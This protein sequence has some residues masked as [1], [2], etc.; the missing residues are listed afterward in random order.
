MH[1]R[2]EQLQNVTSRQREFAERY[3]ATLFEGSQRYQR[4]HI[5]PNSIYRTP[6]SMRDL[7]FRTVPSI[8]IE[9]TED[10]FERLID[11]SQEGEKHMRFREQNPV[12]RKLYEE[13]MVM[14]FLTKGQDQV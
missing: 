1:N 11:A 13:Y 12:A 2:L 9:I 5:S 4:V 8:A 6:M 10:D 14:Y 3:R 7:D